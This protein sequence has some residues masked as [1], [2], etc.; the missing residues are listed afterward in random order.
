MISGKEVP[1]AVA[2]C[3]KLC[4]MSYFTDKASQRE[5]TPMEGGLTNGRQ[6][7]Y[8]P[9][10]VGSGIGVFLVLP[11]TRTLVLSSSRACQLPSL[12]LDAHGEDDCGLRRGCPLR[13]NPT[14]WDRLRALHASRAFDFD[15]LVLQDAKGGRALQSAQLY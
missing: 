5:I 13:R 8:S 2:T 14:R 15:T 1:H 7:L 6:K 11:S 4:G 10:V 3:V 9:L 12:Y